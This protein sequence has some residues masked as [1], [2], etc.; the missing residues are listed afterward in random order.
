MSSRDVQQPC[1]FE[2]VPTYNQREKNLKVVWAGKKDK[3]HVPK[4][5]SRYRMTKRA[6]VRDS[7]RACTDEGLDQRMRLRKTKVMEN[8]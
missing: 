2:A 6:G 3:Y 1:D 8:P 7:K 5:R 4:K